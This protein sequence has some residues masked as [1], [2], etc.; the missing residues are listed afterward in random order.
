MK[1]S[2]NAD[3]FRKLLKKQ[4][5][6][7]KR[8]SMLEVNIKMT[9]DGTS[10]ILQGSF[11]NTA[12]LEAVVHEPGEGFLPLE[13]AIRLLSLCKKGTTAMISYEP[14]YAWINTTRLGVSS[15]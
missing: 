14:G 10:V 11:N 8:R 9:A 5:P 13:S 6:N 3:A 2:V 7:S 15:P 4:K 12:S 1:I